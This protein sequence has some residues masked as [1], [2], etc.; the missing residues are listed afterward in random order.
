MQLLENLIG[1][2]LRFR[3]RSAAG[4]PDLGSAGSRGQWTDSGGRQRHRDRARGLRS[5]FQAIHACGRERSTAAPGSA[6]PYAGASWKPTA[7]S[8]AWNRR[9][10]EALYAHSL[11][12]RHKRDMRRQPRC[13]GLGL[14]RLD[15]GAVRFAIRELTQPV[16]QRPDADPENV[17]GLGL[18]VICVCCRIEVDVGFL[19]F[20]HRGAGP[21]ADGIPGFGSG[22]GI[23]ER[24]T[25]CST[26]FC[27]C[28][29]APRLDPS[30]DASEESFL[31]S[32]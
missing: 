8:F 32:P 18:V 4:D 26:A 6:C 11:C 29:A 21:H 25:D 27:R 31:R 24:W 12:R 28:S 30:R 23:G 20:F 19:D 2:S 1:N 9:R 22:Y 14:R 13:A 5:D 16:V 15:S 3:S 7:E 17:G 10:A